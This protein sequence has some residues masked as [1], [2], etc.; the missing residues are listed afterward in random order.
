MAIS[1]VETPD[2]RAKRAAEPRGRDVDGG[3]ARDLRAD[4]DL[5]DEDAQLTG[6]LPTAHN[7]DARARSFRTVFLKPGEKRREETSI[8]ARR[9]LRAGMWTVGRPVTCARWR[10]WRTRTRS[11]PASCPPPTTL[12][13][14][15]GLGRWRGGHGDGMG[16][17]WAGD[18]GMS[19]QGPRTSP[20]AGAGRLSACRRGAS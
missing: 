2:P 9:R 10:G 18:G 16:R 11:S 1:E 3:S 8:E 6:L 19:P 4:G 7:P 14:E 5:G 13:L 12:M 17:G 20:P 15:R